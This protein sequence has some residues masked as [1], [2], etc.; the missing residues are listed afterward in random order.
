MLNL[1]LAVAGSHYKI[2]SKWLGL[3]TYVEYE[4]WSK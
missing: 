2:G 1:K 4:I 3:T